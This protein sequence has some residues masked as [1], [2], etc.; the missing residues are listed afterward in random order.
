MKGLLVFLICMFC[1]S[2]DGFSAHHHSIKASID[3]PAV[4]KKIQSDF[5]AI[6]KQLKHYKKKAKDVPD[7]SAEGGEVIGY[8]NKN[9]LKKIHC[10]FYGETGRA[11]VD[12]YLNNKGLFFVFRKEICYDKPM[13]VKDSKI[14]NTVETRYYIHSNKVIKSIAKPS[15]SAILSY[16]EIVDDLKQVLD[17]LNSK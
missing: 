14:K 5:S 6:N 2:T 4:I 11:E 1:Y 8:Y 10:V 3:T 7:M 15:T 16:S 9:I 13:Y 17:I 12:Y